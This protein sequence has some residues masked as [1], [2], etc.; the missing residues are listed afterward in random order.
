M[1]SIPHS[2]CPQKSRAV[3][4]RKFPKEDRRSL[5]LAQRRPPLFSKDLTFF[6]KLG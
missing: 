2:G 1:K 4:P 5:E 6:R 3:N